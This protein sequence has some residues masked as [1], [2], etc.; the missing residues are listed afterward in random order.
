MCVGTDDHAQPLARPFVAKSLLGRLTGDSKSGEITG[1]STRDEAP[2]SRSRQTGLVG[3]DSQHEAQEI[4]MS[5]NRLALVGAAGIKPRN[6]GLSAE[7][8]LGAITD[9]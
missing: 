3:D 9:E 5:N 7:M 4:N 8:M 1:G 6:R 2:A